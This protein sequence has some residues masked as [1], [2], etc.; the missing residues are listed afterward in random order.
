MLSSVLRS[1]RAVRI[2]IQIIQTFIRLRRLALT[3]QELAFKIGEL[4]RKTK[5]HDHQIQAV[6]DAIKGMLNPPEATA[7]TSRRRI[8]FKP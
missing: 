8:G 6:F 2:N 7:E 3:H 5:S 4:E 1:Q